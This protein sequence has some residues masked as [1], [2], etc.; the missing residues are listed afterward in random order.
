MNKK[1]VVITTKDGAQR[2]AMEILYT[3]EDVCD[4]FWRF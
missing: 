1:F 2:K 4:Y 3:P